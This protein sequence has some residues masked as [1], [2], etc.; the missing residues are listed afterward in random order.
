MAG[1]FE[2][3]DRSTLF[4]D[5]VG[6]LPLDLQAKLL[7]VLE[8][9]RFE[10]LGSTNSLQADVRIIAAT[11]RDLARE[12]AAGKFRSDLYY[13]LNVF[14][15]AIPPLRE[16]VEDIDPLVWMFVKQSEKKLNKRIDRIPRRNMEALKR[17]PWPGNARE[18]RNII[19][20]AMIL[21][22]GSALHAHPPKQT[23]EDTAPTI[24]LADVERRHIL[25]VLE[26]TGWRVT[27][28]Q[29]AAQML[30]LK[31]TTLQSKMKKLG[32]QRPSG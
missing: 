29:G 30:G 19:E 1:R 14:P 24:T 15:V 16:R 17:Y 31:R 12:V 20:H 4:L 9:G 25:S 26:K 23:S 8:E 27:G 32:I 3:A 10:R 18:L 2:V 5:E 13:R 6:E 7:R 28:E 11:N 21:G 22:R